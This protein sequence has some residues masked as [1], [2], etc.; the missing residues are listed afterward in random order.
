MPRAIIPV[1]RVPL[2][3]YTGPNPRP[4][5]RHFISP[6]LIEVAT[7]LYLSEQG[8]KELKRQVIELEEA[9]ADIRQKNLQLRLR[10]KKLY[11]KSHPSTQTNN[12]DRPLRSSIR[13]PRPKRFNIKASDWEAV[14]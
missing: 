10:N 11:K 2:V 6:K 7:D 14:D 12:K 4:D 1:S 8:E 5:F 9:I 13:Q 3:K